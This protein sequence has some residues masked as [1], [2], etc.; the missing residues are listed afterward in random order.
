MTEDLCLDQ[1]EPLE[2]SNF[3][4]SDNSLIDDDTKEQVTLRT[5]IKKKRRRN[6]KAKTTDQIVLYH[7]NVRGLASKEAELKKFL[8]KK[9][10]D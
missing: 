4:T 8:T 7:F 9:R 10:V 2:S 6:R 5:K 1:N 3:L